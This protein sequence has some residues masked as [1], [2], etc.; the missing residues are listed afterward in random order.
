MIFN[1]TVSFRSRFCLQV[2]ISFE[3]FDEI[4]YVL[5]VFDDLF[6]TTS[7]PFD[8]LSKTF[9]V[10]CVFIEFHRLLKH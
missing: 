8:V 6:T 2:V 10:F 5:I 4:K 1:K 9:D 3:V 7:I